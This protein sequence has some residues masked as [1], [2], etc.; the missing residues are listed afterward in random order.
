MREG[1]YRTIADNSKVCWFPIYSNQNSCGFMK[2]RSF[3]VTKKSERR[4]PFI[5][6]NN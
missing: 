2:L 4:M 5:P 3:R 1:P 6:G